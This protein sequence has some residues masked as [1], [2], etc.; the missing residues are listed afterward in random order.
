MNPMGVLL[1]AL[2]TLNAVFLATWGRAM[3]AA[4]KAGRQDAPASDV[5]FPNAEQLLVGSITNFFDTLGIGSYASTTSWFRIRR[6]V[7]D[8]LIPGTLTVGH[9]IP[10]LMQTLIYTTVVRVD[11]ITLFAMIGAATVGAFLGAGFVAKWPIRRIRV[12]MG[13]LLLVAAILM[14]VG[15]GGPL[16]QLTGVT[17]LP[18]GG[19]ATGVT[20]LKLAIAVGVNFVL[21]ALMTLGIGLYAPC[22]ILVSLLGMNPTVA[23]PI[24]TGSGALLMPVAATRFIGQGSYDSRAALGLVLGGVPAVL[25]AAFIVRSLDVN[26]MKWLVVAVVL[27]TGGTMLR[28]GLSRGARRPAADVSDRADSVRA[29]G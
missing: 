12:G 20:G 17:L 26:A 6:I 2:A 11:L 19:E 4:R 22:M 5:R 27:Y 13:A 16:H 10:V 23:F 9:A 29:D 21:G 14:F 25:V 15:A 28:A 3:L 8:R 18:G 1:A 24:M 7:G